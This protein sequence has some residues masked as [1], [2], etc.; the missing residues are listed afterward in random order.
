MTVVST[1]PA[2]SARANG[3]TAATPGNMGPMGRNQQHRTGRT[4]GR[5]IFIRVSDQE[6]EEIRASAD[7][8]GVSVSRYLVE[9]HETCTDLE[10]A[11]KKCETAHIV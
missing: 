8:N 1:S 11:K 9:A 2:T 7:M 6:F 10:A 5:R 4:R 3:E